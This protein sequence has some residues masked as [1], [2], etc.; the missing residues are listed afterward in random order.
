MYTTFAKGEE[1]GTV[2]KAD[3]EW[4]RPYYGDDYAASVRG[5]LNR[6]RTQGEVNFILQA[7]GLREGAS[8]V[9]LGCGEGRHAL[10]FARRGCKVAALD[11]N[12]A[13]L[14]R[15]REQASHEASTVRWVCADMRTP[16]PGPYDLVLLLFQSFGFFSDAENLHL[17]RD[18]RR[19]LT[20]QGQI[21]VDVWNRERILSDFTPL[22]ERTVAVG[23]TVAEER[24]WDPATQRLQVHYTYRWDDGRRHAYDASFR[25]YGKE[26]LQSLL[27]EAGFSVRGSFG[28][29]FGDGWAPDAPRLVVLGETE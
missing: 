12:P 8:V 14:D 3:V 6:E 5:L 11:L 26:E 24:T 4:F 23:F 15:G 22:A 28:S 1:A 21:V 16:Q 29:L 2:V 18:W 19:E 7:T 10:E 13:F 9:D 25:L 27:V 20:P 17:L